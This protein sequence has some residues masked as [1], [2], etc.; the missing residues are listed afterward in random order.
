LDRD[1]EIEICN[2]VINGASE[3]NEFTIIKDD[4]KT[5]FL[6]KYHPTKDEN[7]NINGIFVAAFDITKRKEAERQ[8][9]KRERE[10]SLIY[11]NVKDGIFLIEN[12]GNNNLKLEL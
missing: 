8:L 1:K 12:E 7:N 6:L 4:T 10:L 3:E 9:I 5:S 2:R 11:N